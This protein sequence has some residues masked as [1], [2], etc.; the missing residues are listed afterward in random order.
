MRPV[1]KIPRDLIP[2]RSAAGAAGIRRPQNLSPPRT[3]RAGIN[4]LSPYVRRV[5]ESRLNRGR[6]RARGSFRST[7]SP[8]RRRTNGV[9]A[10]K[11]R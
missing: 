6:G 3:S 2:S 7:L 1:R 5:F 9:T 11:K 8:G 4:K 10:G